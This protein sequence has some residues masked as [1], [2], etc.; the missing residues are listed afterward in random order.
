[1]EPLLLALDTRMVHGNTSKNG[2]QCPCSTRKTS[3][4][5]KKKYSWAYSWT[6]LHNV[7]LLDSVAAALSKALGHWS[8]EKRKKWMG[9]CLPGM[10]EN[11]NFLMFFSNPWRAKSIHCAGE[12]QI[13]TLESH[14]CQSKWMSMLQTLFHKSHKYQLILFLSLKNHNFKF[15]TS[16]LQG[17][18]VNRL[19]C[20][21]RGLSCTN[22]C[23]TLWFLAWCA[24]W[25]MVAGGY[26]A[27][28]AMIHLSRRYW[29]ST[30]KIWGLL[31][32]CILNWFLRAP[33]GA[34]KTCFSW[35]KLK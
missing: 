13:L 1:M 10:I 25:G 18:R 32:T 31:Y 6:W 15:I 9:G 8:F 33:N 23:S 14:A 29:H 27:M 24:F 7:A 5:T 3:K 21:F 34:K 4:C 17:R 30:D 19:P 22:S 11:H 26:S 28:F 35:Y 16:P 20:F 2:D 12:T